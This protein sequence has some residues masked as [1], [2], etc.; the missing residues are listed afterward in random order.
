[1]I[2]IIYTESYENRVIKFLKKH[3]EL[4]DQYK[5][6]MTLLELNPYH[7]SLRLHQFKT[8]CFS[9][10]SVSINMSYRISIEFQIIEEKIIPVDI[11]D[12][13]EIYGKK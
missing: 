6:T 11:G 7:P 12:H 4:R 1:M 9:G 2:E 3:P 8:S 5:K 10:Y 13:Q